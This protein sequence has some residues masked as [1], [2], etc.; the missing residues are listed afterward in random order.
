MPCRHACGQAYSGSSRERADDMMVLGWFLGLLVGLTL[1]LLG[2]GGSVL[3]VP[4]FVLVMGIDPKPAIAMSLAVV[5]V[6]SLFGAYGHWRERNI[7][8]RAALIFGALAMTGSFI[9]GRLSHHLSG[10]FQLALFGVVMLAAAILM[11]RGRSD[12]NVPPIRL[13]FRRTTLIA[14]PAIGVGVLT[15][16]IGVGGGFLIV[17]ALVLLARV[18]MKPAIGSSL[19]VIAMTAA[20]GFAGHLTRQVRVQWGFMAVFTAF[21][22]VGI[23]AGARLVPRIPQDTLRRAFALFLV[24]MAMLILYQN[25]SAL[26]G[27]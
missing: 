17:P 22:V 8:L 12:A 3:T 11:F 5:G 4:I 20:A 9:G 15:G 10:E 16:L 13:N 26:T 27:M 6:T 23:L 7:D 2:G 18:P 1:G 14:L 24:A 19:L 25:H 21:A